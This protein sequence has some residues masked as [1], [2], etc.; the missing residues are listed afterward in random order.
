M[1][2][3]TIDGNDAVYKAVKEAADRGR[4]GEDTL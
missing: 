4:R 1:P 2:G 3:Y